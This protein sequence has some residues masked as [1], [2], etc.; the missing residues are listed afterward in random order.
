MIIG[1][2]AAVA[3]GVVRV[4]MDLDLAILLNEKNLSQ[5]WKVLKKLGFVIRQPISE[6]LFI[7]P[8]ELL[9][10]SDEKGMKAISFYH[11]KQ[12][13]LVIDILFDKEF[14]FADKDI[15]MMNLFGMKCPILSIEKLIAL[16]KNAGRKKDLEDIDELSKIKKK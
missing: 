13:Y 16:K 5:I 2:F 10:L 4:T 7:Q 1:G 12:Q 9:R 11:K 15:V 3:H 14:Q 6:S 8:K